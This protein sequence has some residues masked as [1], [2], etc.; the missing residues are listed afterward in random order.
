MGKTETLRGK[1]LHYFAKT[2]LHYTKNKTKQKKNLKKPQQQ[3]K[4]TNNKTHFD[5][6]TW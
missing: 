5:N 1:Q 6:E 4:P 3:Q 2:T